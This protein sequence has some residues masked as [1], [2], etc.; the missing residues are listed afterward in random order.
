[1]R[2]LWPH[3]KLQALYAFTIYPVASNIL[4]SLIVRNR[5]QIEPFIFPLRTRGLVAKTHVSI[6][7]LSWHIAMHKNVANP[8][9]FPM[10]IAL[11]PA[12]SK[13]RGRDVHKA[14]QYIFLL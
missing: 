9:L 13:S 1:M 5:F 6:I 2:E 14:G 7:T 3:A 10:Q 11:L 4:T 12:E 8:P